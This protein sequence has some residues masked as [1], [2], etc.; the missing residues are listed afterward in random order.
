MS[1]QKKNLTMLKLPK[2][3]PKWYPIQIKFLD[4]LKWGGD[5]NAFEKAI[6]KISDN[7]DEFKR[8]CDTF[9]ENIRRIKG[10]T[11]KKKNEDEENS[12]DLEDQLLT[13]LH[14]KEVDED[15][16]ENRDKLEEDDCSI[17]E[18]EEEDYQ[19]QNEGKNDKV[20]SVNKKRKH[21]EIENDIDETNQEDLLMNSENNNINEKQKQF[22]NKRKKPVF[23]T[24]EAEIY[25]KC[26]DIYI[27]YL[28][29]KEDKIIKNEEFI[30]MWE[31]Y[32]RLALLVAESGIAGLENVIPLDVL[33]NTTENDVYKEPLTPEY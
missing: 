33:K 14:K 8:Q 25:R 20:S 21:D 16:E 11:S 12:D 2:K 30:I 15:E 1:K 22:P 18:E 10:Y 23:F 28:S 7:W 29:T 26:N 5:I 27:Q 32:R 19:S 9:D 6:N 17:T 31:A 4:E 13:E 24:Q 3:I